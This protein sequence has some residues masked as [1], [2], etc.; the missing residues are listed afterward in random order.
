M[1]DIIRELSKKLGKTNKQVE[2]Y[3]NALQKLIEQ[4]ISDDKIVKISGLGT[5]KLIWNKPRKSVDVRNGQEIEIPGHYKLGFSPD[6][7]LSSKVNEPYAHLDVVELE[8]NNE[9]NSQQPSS[10]IQSQNFTDD[11]ISEPIERLREQALELSSILS[12]IGYAHSA[13][14]NTDDHN[15]N[16]QTTNNFKQEP[17][18]PQE[19]K[20]IQTL[21]SESHT[22]QQ[23][24]ELDSI[25]QTTEQKN[26][27]GTN[28]IDDEKSYKSYKSRRINKYIAIIAIIVLICSLLPLGYF[29][30][31]SVLLDYFKSN[32]FSEQ[33]DNNK[34]TS[35][36][37]SE[38]SIQLEI[39]ASTSDANQSLTGATELLEKPET[40]NDNVLTTAQFK[41]SFGGEIYDQKRFYS[42]FSDT[43]TLVSGSRLTWV[44]YKQFGHKSFWVYIYEAN[45]DHISDPNN[46]SVG[47][48]LRIPVMNL[49]LVDG[50]NPQ[51]I[52]YSKE[53]HDYYVNKQ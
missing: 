31:P 4:G 7:A 28:A 34:N 25:R 21:A 53:L 12:E 11:G 50:N 3:L 9:H 6:S 32:P 16:S 36:I 47:T 44:S 29:C 40:T 45:C 17:Q 5:F 35:D 42:E 14:E 10:Q 13:I 19:P 33:I 23:L 43:I 49:I 39:P 20:Q 52:K 37:Q 24:P 51:S 48:S 27:F 8:D 30:V 1:K 22:Q 46:I 18:E 15:L 26:I 38:Q 2:E 41:S